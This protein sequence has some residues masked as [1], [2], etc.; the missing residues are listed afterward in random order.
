MP[1]GAGQLARAWQAAMGLGVSRVGRVEC[2]F[3]DFV[4]KKAMFA[5]LQCICDI[6]RFSLFAT[7]TTGEKSC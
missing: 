3:I 2:R 5:L 1:Q 4:D 7:C 6:L